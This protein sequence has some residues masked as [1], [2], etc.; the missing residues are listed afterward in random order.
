MQESPKKVYYLVRRRSLVKK[1]TVIPTKILSQERDT[2][3]DWIN[4]EISEERREAR[5]TKRNI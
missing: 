4:S 5:R 3:E 2:K 1:R